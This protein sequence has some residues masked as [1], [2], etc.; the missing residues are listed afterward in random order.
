VGLC[1]A[2]FLLRLVLGWVPLYVRPERHKLWFGDGLGAVADA[3][4]APAPTTPATPETAD[5]PVAAP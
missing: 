2:Y 3:R 1:F 5:D 4:P